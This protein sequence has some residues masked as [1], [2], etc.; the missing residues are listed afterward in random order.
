MTFPF[1]LLIFF[2]AV[3]SNTVY[4]FTS[5]TCSDYTLAPHWMFLYVSG[6]IERLIQEKPCNM[7][8]WEKAISG[9]TDLAKKDYELLLLL[10]V[11]LV[12]VV[13]H[14]ITINPENIS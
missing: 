14:Y 7:C 1:Q 12:V 11:V 2:T 4:S 5:Y 13:P 10:V 6:G 9:K 8:R 3:T